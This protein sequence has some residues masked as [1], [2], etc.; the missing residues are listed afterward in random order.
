VLRTHQAPEP[1]VAVIM[2]C[3]YETKPQFVAP[4]PLEL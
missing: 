3:S 1:G 2:H 4:F